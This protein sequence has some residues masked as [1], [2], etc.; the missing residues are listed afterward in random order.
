MVDGA[1]NPAQQIKKICKTYDD[2]YRALIKAKKTPDTA[3]ARYSYYR[4]ATQM[5]MDDMSLSLYVQGRVL[6]A[7]YDVYEN[8]QKYLENKIRDLV[9]AEISPA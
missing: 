5:V 3:L 4:V 9:L 2:A 7:F 6:D 8:D 1:L